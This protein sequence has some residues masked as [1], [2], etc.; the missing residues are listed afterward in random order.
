MPTAS[1]DLALGGDYVLPNRSMLCHAV[2]WVA[3]IARESVSSEGYI[4]SD[5]W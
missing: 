3:K 2:F 4:P 5:E 1:P